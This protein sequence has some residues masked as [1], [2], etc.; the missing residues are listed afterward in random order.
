MSWRVIEKLWFNFR[1]TSLFGMSSGW[2]YFTLKGLNLLLKAL[3]RSFTPRWICISSDVS[4]TVLSLAAASRCFQQDYA[5]RERA[6]LLFCSAQVLFQVVAFGL[7]FRTENSPVQLLFVLQELLW[8]V[9]CCSRREGIAEANPLLAV[10]LPHSYFTCSLF[11]IRICKACDF[12]RCLP[13]SPQM[14]F[15]NQTLAFRTGFVTQ[16]RTLWSDPLALVPKCQ[17]TSEGLG[18]CH[19]CGVVIRSGVSA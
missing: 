2:L 7:E 10:P 19:K 3:G 4:G 5:G 18:C 9:F 6:L 15:P 11:R 14:P 13:R 8:E 1:G 16:L 12:L 17:F